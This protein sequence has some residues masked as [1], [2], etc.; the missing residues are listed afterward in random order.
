[1]HLSRCECGAEYLAPRPP[2]LPDTALSA[3][4]HLRALVVY[5]LVF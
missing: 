4:P 2:R 5:L 1:M 3:G